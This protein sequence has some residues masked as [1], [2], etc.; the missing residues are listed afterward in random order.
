[1]NYDDLL[2]KAHLQL[3]IDV[4]NA[5]LMQD[6]DDFTARYRR[7]QKIIDDLKRDCGVSGEN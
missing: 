5:K 1:M 4:A 3:A 6:L 7:N 2:R